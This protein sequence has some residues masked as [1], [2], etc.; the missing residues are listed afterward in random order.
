VRL[1][2]FC[3]C[4]RAFFILF[5]LDGKE[6][7]PNA[8]FAACLLCVNIYWCLTCL[9]FIPFFFSILYAQKQSLWVV[10]NVSILNCIESICFVA[11]VFE[12]SNSAFSCT[13]LASIKI[14]TRETRIHTHTHTEREDRIN[15][16]FN[17]MNN[18]NSDAHKYCEG[19]E[20]LD[21]E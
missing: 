7:F 9:Y 3:F 19:P 5:L 17:Q 16:F 15:R 8:H 10:N 12:H 13:S 14:A 21:A 2:F 11:T 1:F 18:F 20:R 6:S 4:A